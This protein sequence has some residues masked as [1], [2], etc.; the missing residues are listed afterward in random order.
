MFYG[1][2]KICPSRDNPEE[3]TYCALCTEREILFRR[4]ELAASV[5]RLDL[6]IC[7]HCAYTFVHT[8]HLCICTDCTDCTLMHDREIWPKKIC[9]CETDG[10]LLF[11]GAHTLTPYILVRHIA[12]LKE[13][14]V[15]AKNKLQSKR[16]ASNLFHPGQYLFVLIF[17]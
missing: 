11:M 9:F 3:C 8:A 10:S 1:F 17:V 6:Y 15:C 12:E 14:E 7:T 4:F 5:R 2:L 13:W 16:F